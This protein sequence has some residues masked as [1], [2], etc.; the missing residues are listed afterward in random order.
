[1]I[2][3][4]SVVL[5]SFHPLGKNILSSQ[6]KLLGLCSGSATY[7][8]NFHSVFQISTLLLVSFLLN[9]SN[10]INKEFNIF[11]FSLFRV[12]FKKFTAETRFNDVF[13]PCKLFRRPSEACEVMT[14]LNIIRQII[15]NS[16]TDCCYRF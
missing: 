1:M 6:Y 15:K 5:L 8:M 12:L 3:S 7:M 14:F 16:W 2:C 13:L 11:L 4:F 10:S 9:S